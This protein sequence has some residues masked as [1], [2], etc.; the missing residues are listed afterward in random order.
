MVGLGNGSDNFF[1]PPD[2]EETGGEAVAHTHTK[3]RHRIH[4]IMARLWRKWLI[5]GIQG[6][7]GQMYKYSI[8]TPQ[9]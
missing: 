1:R 7:H 3:R 9:F 8:H 6:E 2:R 5:L 4:Y